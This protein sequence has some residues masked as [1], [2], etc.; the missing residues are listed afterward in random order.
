MSRVKKFFPQRSGS[1]PKLTPAR[2][3]LRRLAA[4]A[5]AGAH[6]LP[7]L[8]SGTFLHRGDPPASDRH[9]RTLYICRARDS[10]A[11]SRFPA[12]HP[13]F[14]PERLSRCGDGCSRSFIGVLMA[15]V[16]FDQ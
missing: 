3:V 2:P 8:G 5:V 13:T 7:A 15:L 9:G 6:L 16:L 10:K 14:F 1:F 4:A 12:D 11:N